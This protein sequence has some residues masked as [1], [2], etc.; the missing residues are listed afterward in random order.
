M[1]AVLADEPGNLRTERQ[2]REPRTSFLMGQA[3]KQRSNR[4]VVSNIVQRCGFYQGRVSALGPGQMGAL[5]RVLAFIHRLP[6]TNLPAPLSRA[7]ERA[8]RARRLLIPDPLHLW[9]VTDR[10]PS[11]NETAARTCKRFRADRTLRRTRRIWRAPQASRQPALASSS[12]SGT[13]ECCSPGPVQPNVD[14]LGVP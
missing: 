11:L 14:P 10:A 7:I 6:A 5:Q 4:R 3:R 1:I 2:A 13:R 8:Q 12:R 9:G